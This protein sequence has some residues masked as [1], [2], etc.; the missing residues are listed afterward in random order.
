MSLERTPVL[1]HGQF[2]FLTASMGLGVSN[3]SSCQGASFVFLVETAL[4]S[5]EGID[6]WVLEAGS[7]VTTVISFFGLA[8]VILFSS[9]CSP[10]A[11]Q[12]IPRK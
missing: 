5:S 3:F 2:E 11:T 10:A 6:T 7:S 9:G 1:S 12:V 4:L 8:F